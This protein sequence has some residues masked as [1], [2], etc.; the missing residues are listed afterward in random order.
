MP[1]RQV[2]LFGGEHAAQ[3][4]QAP[5][6]SAETLIAVE[7]V[8]A[9]VVGGVSGS[10]GV[11]HICALRGIWV[12]GFGRGQWRSAHGRS[13][14]LHVGSARITAHAFAQLKSTWTEYCKMGRWGWGLVITVGGSGVITG[15]GDIIRGGD[16]ITVILLK[17]DE[18]KYPG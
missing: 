9:D 2:G 10:V 4:I 1:V 3:T 16:I 11:G 12:A 18:D 8:G 7:R 5:G 14:D 15:G 17:V 6:G 13:N